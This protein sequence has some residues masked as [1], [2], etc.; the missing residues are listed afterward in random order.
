MNLLE[1]RGGEGNE[2][3]PQADGLLVGTRVFSAKRWVPLL[4]IKFENYEG[5]E[6]REKQRIQWSYPEINK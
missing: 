3:E 2:K 4:K 6:D 1:G 5:S